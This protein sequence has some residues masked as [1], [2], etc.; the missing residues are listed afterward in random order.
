[1]DRQ[2]LQLCGT[3]QS[4]YLYKPD[5]MRLAAMGVKYYLLSI[6]WTRIL[7]F[8][9]PDTPVSSYSTK[10]YD[11]LIDF[12]LLRIEP[13]LVMK[14]LATKTEPSKMPL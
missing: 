3:M 4:Y 6:S 1:M 5:S 13:T 14:I 2:L 8:R 12:V 11:D 9:L 7:P 10:N